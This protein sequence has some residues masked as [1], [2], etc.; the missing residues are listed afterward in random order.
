MSGMRG[1]AVRRHGMRVVV[2]GI[3]LAQQV[4]A[5]VVSVGRADYRMN[6]VARGR[7][8]V[9]EDARHVI[10]LDEDHRAENAIIERARV[11]AGA[12]P[13]EMRVG[14]MTLRLAVADFGVARPP[15][16]GIGRQ[17]RF[18]PLAALRRTVAM[19]AA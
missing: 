15:A 11:V 5:V 10:E 9:V 13:G 12:D 18:E 17:Q 3:M 7:V 6:M 2:R 14:E 19:A 4:L 16:A 1:M 8:V